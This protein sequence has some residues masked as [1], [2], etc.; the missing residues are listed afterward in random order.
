M[1]HPKIRDYSCFHHRVKKGFFSALF[2]AVQ[3]SVT[4]FSEHSPLF[5]KYYKASIHHQKCKNCC[6]YPLFY[7]IEITNNMRYN[8]TLKQKHPIL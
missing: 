3:K 7:A 1:S 4:H 2:E 8:S 6:K 5:R